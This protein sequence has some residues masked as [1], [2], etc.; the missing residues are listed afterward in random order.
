MF[1]SYYPL[2]GAGLFLLVRDPSRQKNTAAGLDTL[3]VTSSL[4]ILIWN[5]LIM[6]YLQDPTLTPIQIVTS[7][8]FPLVDIL[9]LAVALKFWL[10]P[11]H[12]LIYQLFTSFNCPL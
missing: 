10:A 5:F 4:G 7:I 6:P 8:A 3:I 11:L 12:K 1:L 2:L 9:V